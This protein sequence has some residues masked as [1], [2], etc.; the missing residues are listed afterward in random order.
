MFG[1]ELELG[2][3]S[4]FGFGFV[5]RW[6]RFRVTSRPS[7]VFPHLTVALSHIGINC[8]AQMMPNCQLPNGQASS[9]S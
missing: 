7:S 9:R 8:S 4:T 2:L 3:G 5:S 1:L 6:V